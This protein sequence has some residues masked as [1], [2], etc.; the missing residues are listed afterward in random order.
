MAYTKALLAQKKSKKFIKNF[1]EIFFDL[2]VID[3]AHRGSAAD[4]S[5]WREI[6]EYFNA[7]TQVGMTATPKQETG[8]DNI[9]YFGDPIYTYSLKQGIEDGF[10]APYRVIRVTLDTDAEGFRT[11]SGQ[12]DK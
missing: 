11:Y 6:L 9:E 7:A 8:A 5:A 10:L 1:P 4:D 2:I 3:E 12:V